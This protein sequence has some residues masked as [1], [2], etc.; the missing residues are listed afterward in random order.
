MNQD[1]RTQLHRPPG[2]DHDWRQFHPLQVGPFVLSLRA[3]GCKYSYCKKDL[4]NYRKFRSWD[5][6]ILDLAT[7]EPVCPHRY[8]HLAGKEWAGRFNRGGTPSAGWVPTA[9]VQQIVN[10]LM[11]LR[12]RAA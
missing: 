1:F 6:L 8:P 10:D 12:W 9:V 2:D 5:V 4:L 7:R 11:V 3:S